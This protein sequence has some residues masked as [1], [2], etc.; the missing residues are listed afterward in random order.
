MKKEQ[1]AKVLSKFRTEGKT[2][3]YAEILAA[4]YPDQLIEVYFGD[5]YEQINL[6]DFSPNVYSVICGKIVEA[7]GDCLFIDCYYSDDGKHLKTGNII[8]ING[9]NVKAVT[10]LDGK[11]Q[12]KDALLNPKATARLRNF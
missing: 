10:V 8:V 3:S 1:L 12:I 7:Y 2:A 4:L 11:G 5:V 6:A 9:F